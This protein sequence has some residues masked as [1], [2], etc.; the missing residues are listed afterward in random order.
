MRPSSGKTATVVVQLATALALSSCTQPPSG[1]FESEEVFRITLLS[2]TVSRGDILFVVDDSPGMSAIRADFAAQLRD[3][4]DGLRRIPNLDL[5]IALTNGSA[6][7]PP[8]E[9]PCNPGPFIATRIDSADETWATQIASTLEC[10]AVAAPLSTAA[11]QPLSAA[12]A[13][14]D[15]PGFLRD[16]SYLTIIFITDND[17]TSSPDGV[18]AG[19]LA[20]KDVSMLSIYGFLGTP[21]DSCAGAVPATRL[22][23]LL[24]PTR[25]FFTAS[26]CAMPWPDIWPLATGFRGPSGCFPALAD[27]ANPQCSVVDVAGFVPRQERFVPACVTYGPRPCWHFTDTPQCYDVGAAQMLIDRGGTDPVEPTVSLAECVIAF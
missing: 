3:V 16:N 6:G 4:I 14:L 19:L 1:P 8:S 25:V 11:Q 18:V 20:R 27:P 15:T 2:D 12:Y 21:P 26:F 10:M 22:V 9:T 24:A 5:H 17:D 7:V 23:E 13:A